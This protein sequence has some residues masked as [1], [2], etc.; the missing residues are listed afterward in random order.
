MAITRAWHR[1][2]SANLKFLLA[3][4]V[5]LFAATTQAQNTKGDK[6][7]TSPTP[8]KEGKGKLFGK[9]RN[10]K[11]RPGETR[12]RNK[13]VF[14]QSGPYVNN[15]S[16]EPRKTPP[17]NSP[18]PSSR[19]AQRASSRGRSANVYPQ[20][21]PYVNNPSRTPKREKP[22]TTRLPSAVTSTTRRP[23]GRD[24][25]WTNGTVSGQSTTPRSMSARTQ[26]RNIYPQRGPFVNNPSMKAKRP[27]ASP[28]NQ[29]LSQSRRLSMS[30]AAAQAR[31]MGMRGTGFQTI[32]AQFLSR[33]K[34]N[35]Y[36]GKFRKKE[37]AITTDIAGRKLRTRNYHSPK[38]GLVG[39]DTLPFFRRGPR[40]VKR[41]PSQQLGGYQS[42]TRT[43]RA[44][45]GDISGNKLRRQTARPKSERTGNPL[46]DRPQSVSG[47]RGR[48]S[49]LPV[50]VKPPG[51]GG[52]AM[53]SFSKR[54]QGQRRMK[55]AGG[56]LSGRVWNNKNQPVPGKG[57][58]ISSMRIS[59]FSGYGKT[60]RS[61]KGGGSVSGRLW[62]NQNTAVTVRKGGMG[63]IQAAQ[64]KGRYKLDGNI[65]E[66]SSI[67]LNFTGYK[68]TGRP[69]KGGGSISGKTWNN[70]QTPLAVRQGGRGS[71]MAGAFQGNMKTGRPA[72]GG[73]SVSGQLWNNNNTPV[74]GKG[75]PISSMRVSGFSGNIKSRRP[76]KGGGSI[77]HDQWNN[78]GQATTVR[79]AGTGTIQA[80]QFKGRQKGPIAGN[81][82]SSIGLN[83]TG[84]QKAKKPV[85][86]G[87]SI[88]GQ[89]W[90]N[91]NQPIEVHT[92]GEGSRKGGLYQG[93]I[94]YQKKPETAGKQATFSGKIPGVIP[95][96]EMSAV[97]LNYT[98]DYK[99]K[100]NRYVQ[101]SKAADASLKKDRKPEGLML[102]I[103]IL[104]QTKRSVNA[105]HY[106]HQMKQYW[107]YKRAPNSAKEAL[108]MREPG[109]ATARIGDL[110]VNVKMRKY[111]DAQMH[112]DA[113]FAHSYRDNVKGERTLL[114]NVRLAWAKLFKKSDN[115]PRNLKEK[116]GKIRFDP[117]ENAK[118]IWYK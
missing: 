84:F 93:N 104:N 6:P 58:P 47:R 20:R 100:R 31:S 39:R 21:G 51:L 3:L 66:F 7:A 53:A 33:G 38:M 59:G 29:P 90:N 17:T 57:A 12:A 91:K 15:P 22:N 111:N 14:P 48:A 115:Q 73:G 28:R 52:V 43:G 9:M 54:A 5:V 89:M 63:T 34:K 103:P 114:M 79:K 56:S 68:K 42:A 96:N 106:V 46:R 70:S 118:G 101:N 113:R 36:W 11:A 75:A 24:K 82:L 80:A 32:T 108:K 112:P 35:V 64:F 71:R 98:G 95:G 99:A 88:S 83:F 94:K 37:Q 102:N 92:G 87:G 45:S 50:P 117:G 107:D 74:S 60:S 2:F 85:K 4:V 25:A 18:L 72:K 109:R 1:I 78:N 44:W 10:G 27:D 8:P 86:G 65:R 13:K 49:A 97:G 81:E 41:G 76:A 67:G 30:K 40:N 110:Q 23:S 77:R 62:N 55:G 105:G 61:A 19:I 69:V 16:K 116:P 26:S